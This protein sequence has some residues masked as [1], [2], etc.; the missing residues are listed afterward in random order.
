MGYIYKAFNIKND[1]FCE[2]LLHD[3]PFSENDFEKPEII[4]GLNNAGYRV[5]EKQHSLTYYP[6][7]SIFKMRMLNYS[8]YDPL[9]DNEEKTIRDNLR[10]FIEE[11]KIYMEE[12]KLNDD[13]FM[14]NLC[15][16]IYISYRTFGTKFATMYNNARQTSQGTQRCYNVNHTPEDEIQ[17]IYSSS[18]TLTK[19]KLQRQKAVYNNNN[20]DDDITFH[21]LNH[22]V[23]GFADAPYLTPTSTRLMRDISSSYEINSDNNTELSVEI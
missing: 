3:L 8:T 17:K 4:I 1:F 22:T 23:S 14:K 19:P 9:I 5:N 2:K 7:D 16:D 15:D 6:S 11:M 20:N 12:N 10:K 13:K 21:E 18:L